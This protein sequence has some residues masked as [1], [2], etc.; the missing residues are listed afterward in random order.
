LYNDADP[1]DLDWI[2]ITILPLS[3]VSDPHKP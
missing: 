1:N 2:W 3:S